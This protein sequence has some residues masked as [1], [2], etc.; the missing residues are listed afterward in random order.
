MHVYGSE[1]SQEA[2]MVDLVRVFNPPAQQRDERRRHELGT[3]R[4]NKRSDVG[5]CDAARRGLDIWDF[6]VRESAE[7]FWAPWSQEKGPLA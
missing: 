4:L 7:A 2:R 5:G 3:R 1:V 6:Q